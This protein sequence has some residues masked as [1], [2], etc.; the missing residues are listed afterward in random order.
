MSEGVAHNVG[1]ARIDIGY[2]RCGDPA[3]PPV[4]LIMGGGAQMINWPEGFCTELV[5]RG[6]QVIRFD[7]RDTGRST[8][9]ADAPVPDVRGALAGDLSCVSSTLSDM[10]ADSVGLLDVLRLDGAHM[11]GA[12]LGGMV[13]QTVAIEYPD[14]VRSL[15][16][17]FSTTGD[18]AVGQADVAALGPI[19]AP[20]VDRRGYIDWQ[21]RAMRAVGSPGFAFDEAGVADRAARSYDRGH[22]PVGMLRQAV[23]V[24][25]SGTAPTACVSARTDAGEARNRRQD[26]RHQ[27]RAGHGCGRPRREA[28]DLRRHGPPPAAGAVGGAGRVHRWAGAAGEPLI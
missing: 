10:V 22:D 18:R 25:A 7:G 8:H 28:G 13:A 16:S 2:E 15:T 4:L 21:V 12:S 20:P 27:R 19:G 11:V 24:V 9:F 14:R 5:D 23:A 1:P 26:E 17:M 6:L 3:A